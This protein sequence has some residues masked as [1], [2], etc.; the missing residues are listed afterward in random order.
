MK[1]MALGLLA[2]VGLAAA[3]EDKVELSWKGDIRLRH[4]QTFKDNDEASLG[5]EIFNEDSETVRRRDRV[6]LRV[7]AKAKLPAGFEAN[8]R[9]A[10]GGSN[11][12]STNQSYKGAFNGKTF[13]LD[14]AFLKWSQDGAT[15][16]GG[17]MKNPFQ[18][19]HKKG[20]TIW[21]GDV[22]PEGYAASYNVAGVSA[23]V[24]NFNLSEESKGTDVT[25]Q[26]A[27]LVYEH[28]LEVV[29]VKVGGSGY[30]FN[31][32]RGQEMMGK[33]AYGN[34][35]YKTKKMVLN[36]EGLIEEVTDKL[37]YTN[38]YNLVEGWLDVS[39]KLAGIPVMVSGAY[40]QNTEIDENNIGFLGALSLGKVKKALDWSMGYQYRQM[41]KDATVAAF[42]SSDLAG[43][44]L[45]SRAHVVKA[46]LGLA[47]GVSVDVAAF[48]NNSTGVS[49]D[50]VEGLHNKVQLNFVA[51]F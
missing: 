27:Q 21:D 12:V 39:A 50:V 34:S 33:G 51:K 10:T 46:K 13:Q 2:C 45:D 35:S 16:L 47:K 36:K 22:N 3:G 18:K 23:T 1:T 29:K 24:A 6:R 20:E 15:L 28:D 4:E 43:Q 19:P 31:T 26:G 25:M 37:F 48:I 30:Y 44:K 41:D 9:L 14:Q 17:K 40:V 32:L 7:G 49:D 11:A 8:L 5:E 42:S 38:N